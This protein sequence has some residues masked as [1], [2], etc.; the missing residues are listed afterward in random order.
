MSFRDCSYRC[1]YTCHAF[2]DG[3]PQSTISDVTMIY[4]GYPYGR[5]RSV[6][7]RHQT[8]VYT[9]ELHAGKTTSKSQATAENDSRP[10]DSKRWAPVAVDA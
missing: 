9:V 8:S 3:G 7:K 4:V 5:V 10:R 2:G 6:G 1:G